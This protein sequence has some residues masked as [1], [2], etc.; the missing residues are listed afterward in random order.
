MLFKTENW[1]SVFLNVDLCADLHAYQYYN[2]TVRRGKQLPGM[3]VVAV[4]GIRANFN[5]SAFRESP[6]FSTARR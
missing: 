6:V 5:G 2:R 4:T 1:C 3:T